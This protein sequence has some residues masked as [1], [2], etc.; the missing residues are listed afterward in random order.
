MCLINHYDET[1][2]VIS[3]LTLKTTRFTTKWKVPCS[4][5]PR[6]GSL[7]RGGDPARDLKSPKKDVR[8]KLLIISY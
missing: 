5:G 7:L 6:G 2:F 1:C 8:R 3:E 4:P